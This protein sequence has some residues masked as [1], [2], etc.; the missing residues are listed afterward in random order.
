MKRP[1]AAIAARASVAIIAA[2]LRATA[3][4]S[5]STSI[6]MRPIPVRGHSANDWKTL[7]ALGRARLAVSCLRSALGFLQM[8]TE[9]ITHSRQQLVAEIR[10]AARAETFVE[11]GRK[12]GRRHGLVDRRLD[13]P[14]PFAG[15]G[16]LASEVGEF[17]I[18]SQ[19]GCSEVEQP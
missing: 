7:I 2:A 6:F 10:L 4:S 1:R 9:F 3:S 14:A 18:F 16:D 19:R 15:V 13:R 11:G 8:S 12:Y 17:G 5:G